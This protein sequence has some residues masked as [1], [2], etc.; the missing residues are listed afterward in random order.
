M[1]EKHWNHAF[2]LAFAVP[3]ST[4]EDWWACLE[5][6]AEKAEIRDALH[7]RIDDL[8]GPDN[9]YREALTGFDTYE[10]EDKP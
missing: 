4:H 2:D 10:E 5:D 8:F 7:E 9:E 6:P 1:K 3:G